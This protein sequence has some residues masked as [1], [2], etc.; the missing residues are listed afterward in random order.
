VRRLQEFLNTQAATMG[1]DRIGADGVYGP[2]TARTVARLQLRTGR[3]PTGVFSL[4]LWD[5]LIG[6]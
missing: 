2:Q 1:F 3:P 5:E 6:D 4:E